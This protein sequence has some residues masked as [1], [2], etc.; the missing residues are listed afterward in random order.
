MIFIA[1]IAFGIAAWWVIPAPGAKRIKGLTQ[2]R[3][4]VT[5]FAR[6]SAYR[7][8]IGSNRRALIRETKTETLAAINALAAELRAGKDPQSALI[9]AAGVPPVWPRT[10]TVAHNHGDTVSALQADAID[11]PELRALAACWRVGVNSGSGLAPSIDSLA[12]SL[13]Q[14]QEVRLHLEAELASPRAT[15]RMLAMLP[16]V[17][18]GLGYL[19]GADPLGWLLSGVLGVTVLIV[20]VGLT[21]AGMWWTYR[22]A[23]KVERLL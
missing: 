10:L 4:P 19:M 14:A 20:G 23:E 7:N 3:E 22:I 6:I 8:R 18:I 12:A 17:G 11:R 9:A 16:A 1:A 2:A 15:A 5:L 21:A 13:R